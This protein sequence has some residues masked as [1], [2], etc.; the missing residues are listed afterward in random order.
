M[1]PA[2]RI[3][4]ALVGVLLLACV[5]CDQA[6]KIAA[7]DHLKGEASRSF[8][9]DTFRFIYAENAG[10]FLGLGTSW[11]KE[12][13][14]IVLS[15]LVPILL[16][17]LLFAALSPKSQ[18]KTAM[19]LTLLVGG[20][21]G[22]LVDR[23]WRDGRVVDFMNMGVGP[24]RTGIFN[25]ADVQLMIGVGLL[26][27]W[28]FAKP[29]AALPPMLPKDAQPPDDDRAAD[30]ALARAADTVAGATTRSA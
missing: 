13:R 20:G 2:M 26:V 5:G 21:L 11:P 29:P 14:V 12:A 8:F 27:V 10:A 24:V 19:A 22:N 4:L 30:A 15:L 28:S 9:Y 7:I 6:T 16:G 3:R 1:F 25:V 23:I 17:G 18:T